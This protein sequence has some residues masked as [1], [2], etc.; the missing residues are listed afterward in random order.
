MSQVRQITRSD[1]G[2]IYITEPFSMNIPSGIQGRTNILADFDSDFLQTIEWFIPDSN[3]T[4]YD[5]LLYF[6]PDNASN[7]V[8]LIK[9][10]AGTGDPWTVVNVLAPYD[11]VWYR[12][13]PSKADGYDY[14]VIT[15]PA[16]I[17]ND[18]TT[19]ILPEIYDIPTNSDNPCWYFDN[20]TK[21]IYVSLGSTNSPAE[22]AISTLRFPKI[23]MSA[24]V[25]A[26]MNGAN[27]ITT[28]TPGSATKPKLRYYIS[29]VSLEASSTNMASYLT[30]GPYYIQVRAKCLDTVYGTGILFDDDVTLFS[31]RFIVSPYRM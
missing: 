31:G 9:D 12:D 2:T 8:D 24:V 6:H 20:D 10:A 17:I 15:H 1:S 26:D 28:F 5:K 25:T 21:K 18:N 30:N 3:I 4:T 14:D 23:S 11:Q 27:I 13:A 19:S 29:G 22:N 16:Y 7:E